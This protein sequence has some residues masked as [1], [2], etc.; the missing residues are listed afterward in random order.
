[1]SPCTCLIS[2]HV[3]SC[4]SLDE[5]DFATV[6]S[7]QP[8]KWVK[9]PLFGVPRGAW[10]LGVMFFLILLGAASSPDS[11]T[12]DLP[13]NE[14][15]GSVVVGGQE[16]DQ[17]S[18][19]ESGDVSGDSE[20]PDSSVG[21]GSISGSAVPGE[22]RPST[23]A[24]SAS[25]SPSISTP[26][27]SPVMPG[28]S[29]GPGTS[30]LRPVAPLPTATAPPVTSAPVGTSDLEILR[31]EAE[32]ERQGY[33]RSLFPHWNDVNGSG[34]TARQ[35]VLL[36]QVV[37][38]PQV[39]L[40]DR[41]VIVEADWYSLFDAITHSGSPSE[42]DVDH[43]VSLAEAWDSGAWAWDRAQRQRFANDPINLLAVTASSNRSKSDRDAGE[44]TPPQRSA[45]CMTAQI[46][47]QTKLVY[48]LSVDP[49][50]KRG[51]STMLATCGQVGQRVV[52]GVPLLPVR[53]TGPTSTTPTSTT[54]TSTTTTA[55]PSTAP[56]TVCVNVNTAAV[57]DL[58]RIIH[59]G[60][61]RAEAMLRLR[62]F[63]SIEDL[64]R[65]DGIG[66]ARLQD[67]VS[68]GLACV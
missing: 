51:L 47:V 46:M 29:T 4:H 25:T 21:S 8:V 60:P 65:I 19:Q 28:S 15:S 27:I 44:W 66:P 20:S 31:V 68:Q 53:S 43:V 59:I 62:P 37:G 50:E 52:S 55:A 49:Q 38:L 14:T 58:V 2:G 63:R 56:V 40:F 7:L 26:A 35:D 16:S 57:E 32:P 23:P 41:C 54:P 6:T 34:C 18:G 64:V 13:Q 48:G 67:I 17:E 42:L 12:T 22:T 61:A 3:Y 9:A 30:P 36:A 10:I 33:S 11:E 5:A 24:P 1:M 45:W 39:D